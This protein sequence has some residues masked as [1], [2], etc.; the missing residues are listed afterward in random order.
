MDVP[1]ASLLRRETHG[2]DDTE[3]NIV[4]LPGTSLIEATRHGDASSLKLVDIPVFTLV[5]NEDHGHGE[6]DNKFIK[7]PI[8]G[9]LFRHKRTHNKEK[10]RFLIF[11]HTR[12]LDADDHER[13]QERREARIEEQRRERNSRY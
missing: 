1:F 5:D 6:F 9:S 7:L 4:N 2:P 10:I 3:I 8:I 12:T 13:H 11:S